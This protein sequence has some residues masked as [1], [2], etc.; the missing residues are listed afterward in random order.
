MLDVL[1]DT[2]SFFLKNL[3]QIIFI[4]LPVAVLNIVLDYSLAY[5][6]QTRMLSTV[7]D[8]FF[9]PLY[10]GSL[11]IFFSK[12]MNGEKW[13][14]RTL[15]FGNIPFY[16]RL[17]LV[18]IVSEALL[19][20]GLMICIIPGL[21][22]S[23]KLSFAKFYVVL[24]NDTAPLALKKSWTH[25]R[26]YTWPIIGSMTILFIPLMLITLLDGWLGK[27][28]G[29]L[30]SPVIK[31]S[32]KVYYTIF[33][34]LFFRFFC[35]FTSKNIGHSTTFK[36]ND[37]IIVPVPVTEV[38]PKADT[39]EKTIK[40]HKLQISLTEFSTQS[41]TLICIFILWWIS[42]WT[43]GEFFMLPLIGISLLVFSIV[44]IFQIVNI[45]PGNFLFNLKVIP[46]V[47]SFD[48]TQFYWL[49]LIVYWYLFFFLHTVTVVTR[50]YHWF[51][52][53]AAFL[54]LTAHGCDSRVPFH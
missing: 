11:I 25:T 24:E 49:Y 31:C 33:T 51:L 32:I 28:R 40:S 6:L 52:F 7:V 50:K 45:F 3:L 5:A 47:L 30:S 43:S 13:N 39:Q 12:S 4:I 16:S 17:F 44:A 53:L 14:L 20:I 8:L 34:V 46:S 22:I 42:A 18:G 36:T 54:I 38:L 10:S 27:L 29:P 2:I 23:A 48:N 26:E 15:Y 9:Y 35:L 41:Q 1:R 37:D 21:I 19:L